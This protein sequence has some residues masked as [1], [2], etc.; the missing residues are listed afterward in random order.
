MH[1]CENCEQRVTL[2]SLCVVLVHYCVTC[3][4]ISRNIGITAML[5]F[6]LKSVLWHPGSMPEIE[7]KWDSTFFCE[8]INNFGKFVGSNFF[9]LN[10]FRG[11]FFGAQIFYSPQLC[12]FRKYF[13]VDLK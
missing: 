3:L 5:L 4:F 11:N 13:N 2:G 8:F 7:W 6:G 9:L 1:N 12:K 10:S